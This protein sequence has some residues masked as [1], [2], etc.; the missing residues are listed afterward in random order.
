MFHKYISVFMPFNND[1]N[2]LTETQ[3]NTKKVL[4]AEMIIQLRSTVKSRW[5]NGGKTKAQTLFY[6]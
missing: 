5:Q 1:V 4:I 3:A 2:I 6:N